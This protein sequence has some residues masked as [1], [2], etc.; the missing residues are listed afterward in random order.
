[1]H[2]AKLQQSP[3]VAVCLVSTGAWDEISGKGWYIRAIWY[4]GIVFAL[5]SVRKLGVQVASK[6]QMFRILLTM[7]NLDLFY[8]PILY[9]IYAP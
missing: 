1:M 6:I 3:L 4:S 9:I 7:S 8:L 2:I 5:F